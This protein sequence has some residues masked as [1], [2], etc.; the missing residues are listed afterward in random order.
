LNWNSIKFLLPLLVRT[1]LAIP[2][3]KSIQQI[4][5]IE[6]DFELKLFDLFSQSLAKVIKDF[7]SSS[8]SCVFLILRRWLCLPRNWFDMILRVVIF[9]LTLIA[10][11]P[12]DAF[13]GIYRC[14][15][16][17]VIGADAQK[18]NYTTRNLVPN[19]MFKI[20]LNVPRKSMKYISNDGSVNYY[21]CRT[22]A[23]LAEELWACNHGF[24]N[25]ILNLETGNFIHT[26]VD[27]I[28]ASILSLVWVSYGKCDMF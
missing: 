16:S 8:L 4:K 12:T 24:E 17:T 25:V 26:H 19:K 22:P 1:V 21:T 5:L 2:R 7:L 20:R 27:G 3:G 13:A 14:R 9:S 15:T 6:A 28:S 11:L 23:I 10:L 18:K